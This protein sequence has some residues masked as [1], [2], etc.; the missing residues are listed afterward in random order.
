MKLNV[1]LDL[2]ETV[3]DDW[4]SCCFLNHKIEKIKNLINQ[5]SLEFL[6]EKS[7]K[8]NINLVLFSA[9]IIN[10]KDLEEFNNS[11][12][13][14]LEENFE[15]DFKEIIMFDNKTI[16]GL[17]RECGIKPTNEDTIH[18]IFMF[19]IKEEVFNLVAKKNEINILFDDTVQNKVCFEGS[20]FKKNEEI[21]TKTTKIFVNMK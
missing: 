4:F 18:D 2:E 14:I 16:F 5:F 7:N 21:K 17:A 11:I 12:K 20:F 19:N 9:A 13:P 3:I 1:F 10:E 8:N 15:L 6:K